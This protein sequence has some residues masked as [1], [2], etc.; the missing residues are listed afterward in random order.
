MSALLWY[1]LFASTLREM[2]FIINPY[3]PCVANKEI[4]GKQCTIV[5][6]V[7]DLKV[8]HVEEGVVKD[9]MSKIS[10]RYKGLEAKISDEHTYLGMNIKYHKDGTVSIGMEEYVDEVLDT[11]GT[12]SAITSATTTPARGNLFTVDEKSERLKKHRSEIFHHCVAKLLYV[13]KKCRLDILLAISFLCSRVTNSTEEDWLKLKRVLRYLYGTKGRRLTLGADNLSIVDIFIDVSYGVHPDMRSHTGGCITLGRG[14]LMSM[15]TKQKLNTTSSTEAELVGCSDFMKSAIYAKLFLA[16][17]GYVIDKA[18]VNQ[19][20]ESTIKLLKNGRTSCS[21]RSRHIDIRYFFMKDR[22]DKGEFDVTYCPTELMIAD[23]FT[24]P[25]Q[26][27]LY[28]KL[29]A[30][31]MGEV[32]MD[33]FMESYIP[34]TK[35]RVGDNAISESIVDGKDMTRVTNSDTTSTKKNKNEQNIKK[36]Q[37]KAH[38]C[39]MRDVCENTFSKR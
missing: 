1:E 27:N 5:W 35:E 24:K 21:K 14:A 32:D 31:V 37:L 15:A 8:S 25:I 13:S 9:V 2:G 11:F 26:G 20:N 23:F 7:D 33:T 17:Q 10:K 28:R 34:T 22:I 3:E 36:E 29:S 30:V 6:Y 18:T 4:N 38:V 39:E 16:K 19:D 12:E